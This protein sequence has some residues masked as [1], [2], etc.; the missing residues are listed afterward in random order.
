ML[1]LRVAVSL[2]RPTYSLAFELGPRL[3]MLPA[4]VT[5]AALNQVVAL[6]PSPML[7]DG[8]PPEN[9]VVTTNATSKTAWLGWTSSNSTTLAASSLQ[10]LRDRSH[11]L[12]TALGS[13][14]WREVVA[15]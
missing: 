5:L 1:A 15:I 2:W 4:D 11:R 3:R 10:N 8:E 13:G 14:G 6:S 12:P 7:N 9:A